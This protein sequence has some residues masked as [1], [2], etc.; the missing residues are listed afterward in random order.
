[1]AK[2]DSVKL[3]QLCTSINNASDAY[4]RNVG[5]A[6][7]ELADTFN[8]NWCSPAAT[9]LGEEISEKLHD[10]TN[11]VTQVFHDKNEAVRISVDNF[12]NQEEASIVFPGFSFAT[13]ATTLELHEKLPDGYIGVAEGA[14]LN[15]IST[16]MDKVTTQVTTALQSVCDAAARS[17]AFD[18]G[19][20]GALRGS[21]NNIKS[22][23]EQAMAELKSSL[24]TRMSGEIAARAEL[25]RVNIENLG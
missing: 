12:N 2:M 21:V 18:S 20:M 8:N 1:M 14:D 17:E 4:V 10:L 25:D 7:R 3:G 16:A 13:P 5:S 24:A 9:K 23:F 15:T 11:S 22:K 6:V 19:E